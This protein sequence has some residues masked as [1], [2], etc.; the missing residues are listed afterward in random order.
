MTTTMTEAKAERETKRK[1]NVLRL[2]GNSEIR[3]PSDDI[4]RRTML[5][6]EPLAR[7]PCEQVEEWGAVRCCVGLM[8]AGAQCGYGNSISEAL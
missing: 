8:R 5:S 4:V 1:A 7:N 6:V 3:Y 2:M